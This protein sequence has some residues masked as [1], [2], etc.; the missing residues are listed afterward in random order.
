MNHSGNL[1]CVCKGMTCDNEGKLECVRKVKI[2]SVKDTL[3]KRSCFIYLYVHVH[4]SMCIY[5]LC[6]TGKIRKRHRIPWN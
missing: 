5:H 4:E 1:G 6:S 2:H 3:S